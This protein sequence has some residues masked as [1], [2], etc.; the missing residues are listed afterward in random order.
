MLPFIKRVYAVRSKCAS[1]HNPLTNHMLRTTDTA[2]GAFLRQKGLL[3]TVPAKT[4]TIQGKDANTDYPREREADRRD[5]GQTCRKG[6]F[7]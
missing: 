1:A 2:L 5:T 7:P 3:E 4:E 6:G